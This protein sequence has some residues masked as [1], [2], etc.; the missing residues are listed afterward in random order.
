MSFIGLSERGRCRPSFGLV[1]NA[2]GDFWPEKSCEDKVGVHVRRIMQQPFGVGW[3]NY[4]SESALAL[5]I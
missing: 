4:I 1:E 3:I 2:S 5:S